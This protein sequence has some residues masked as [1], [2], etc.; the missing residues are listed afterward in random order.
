MIN[1]CSNYRDFYLLSGEYYRA[2][3]VANRAILVAAEATVPLAMAEAFKE[4]NIAS[5]DPESEDYGK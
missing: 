1:L 4:G 3:V 2:K 5:L